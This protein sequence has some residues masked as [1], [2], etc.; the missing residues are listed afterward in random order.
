VTPSPSVSTVTVSTTTTITNV[1]PMI[2]TT[3]AMV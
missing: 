2:V 1:I 3:T